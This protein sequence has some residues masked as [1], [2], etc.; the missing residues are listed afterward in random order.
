M[1]ILKYIVEID[2][3]EYTKLCNKLSSFSHLKKHFKKELLS[4]S[5]MEFISEFVSFPGLGLST[6]IL[7]SLYEDMQRKNL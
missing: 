4:K 1:F 6:K 3:K 2:E 5:L 7:K